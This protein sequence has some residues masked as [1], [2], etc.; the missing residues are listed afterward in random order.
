MDYID[1]EAFLGCTGLKRVILKTKHIKSDR[2][3][4]DELRGKVEVVFSEENV[5]S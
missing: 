5:L 2:F 1:D 4:P 3:L